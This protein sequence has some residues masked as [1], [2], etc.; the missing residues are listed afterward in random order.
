[1]V[2][3][4]MLLWLASGEA[5]AAP[6]PLLPPGMFLVR[7][8]VIGEEE[9][10]SEIRNT[11]RVEHVYVGEGD[12]NAK[13]FFAFSAEM[14]SQR[15]SG[16]VIVPRLQLGE[17]GIWL[18]KQPNDQ[19][20]PEHLYN[21]AQWPA[22][23]NPGSPHGPSYQTMYDFAKRVEMIA[24]RP[25]RDAVIASL[26]RSA[27]NRNPYIS[28][29]AISRLAVVATKDDHVASFLD[30]LISVAAVPMQGQ[31]EL[32][33]ALIDVR[34]AAWRESEKRFGIFRGWLESQPDA[35][36]AGLVATHL[37]IV[38]QHPNN[39]G[40]TQ[41]NLLR[42]AKLLAENDRFPLAARAQAS[43]V[44]MSAARRYDTDQEVFKLAAELV[45]SDLPEEIRRSVAWVFVHNFDLD[46]PRR[47]ALRD[48]RSK[49][50]EK[51]VLD[52]LDAALAR[53]DKIDSR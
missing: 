13:T 45:D 31:I 27:T 51:P 14:E 24:H 7:A 37:Q 47:Q 21:Y 25:K 49:T 3:G 4:I 11:L 36:D 41:S 15:F 43:I 10:R 40:F 29:W 9:R 19:L 5:Q 44:V 6:P 48:L 42:L 23:I 53:S 17:E 22:R 16:N 18:V 28:S 34:G 35:N 12:V 26:K 46:E 20:L 52:A 50:K 39:I 1:M 8:V 38:S 32:D 2:T 30:Q 33:N